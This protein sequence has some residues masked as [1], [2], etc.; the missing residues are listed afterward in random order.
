M[1]N[2]HSVGLQTFMSTSKQ[3]K[4][5]LFRNKTSCSEDFDYT[6]VFL[7]SSF[8]CLNEC[9]GKGNCVNPGVV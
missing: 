6:Y 4:V 9:V 1:D 2:N 3:V 8:M 7:L 5:L